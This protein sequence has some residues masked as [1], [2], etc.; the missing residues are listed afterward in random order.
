[1]ESEKTSR[2]TVEIN[3]NVHTNLK[4][5]CAGL[6]ISMKEVVEKSLKK[7]IDSMQRKLY[8]K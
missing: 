4:I 1:M 7:E 6:K 3:K 2:F 8:A 5:L